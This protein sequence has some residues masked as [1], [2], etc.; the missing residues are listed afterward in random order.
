[1]WI[2]EHPD[3]LGIRSDP[4]IPAVATDLASCLTASFNAV[5]AQD[6]PIDPI[7]TSTSRGT[8]WDLRGFRPDSGC[9]TGYRTCP[10]GCWSILQ[11]ACG[12]HV[13]V[14]KLIE[15]SLRMH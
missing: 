2:Q 15:E 10:V 11:L 13:S 9:G 4:V 3:N 12:V 14:R 5:V 7:L 1:M 8:I 6:R